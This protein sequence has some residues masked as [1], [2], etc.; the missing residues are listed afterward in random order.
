MVLKSNATYCM[1]HDVKWSRKSACKIIQTVKISM[2]KIKAM[3][4]ITF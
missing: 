3:V 4:K 2:K 1:S